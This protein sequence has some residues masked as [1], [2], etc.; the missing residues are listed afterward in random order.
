MNRGVGR[1]VIEIVM[2]K[3]VAPSGYPLVVTLDRRVS[4]TWRLTVDGLDVLG[5]E[6]VTCDDRVL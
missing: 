2:G 6:S 3:V 5:C 4:V 1:F